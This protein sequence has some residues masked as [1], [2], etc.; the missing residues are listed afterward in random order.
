MPTAVPLS[1]QEV[2][3]SPRPVKQHHALGQGT[4]FHGHAYM[5]KTGTST[6][7]EEEE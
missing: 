7:T 4:R 5:R 1:L 6:H 2:R 3:I